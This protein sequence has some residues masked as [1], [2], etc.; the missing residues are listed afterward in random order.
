MVVDHRADLLRPSPLPFLALSGRAGTP[1][2]PHHAPHLRPHTPYPRRRM[3]S[4]AARGSERGFEA[5]WPRRER[6]RTDEAPDAP[7]ES[8]PGAAGWTGDHEHKPQ[9][10]QPSEATVGLS[11]SVRPN[12]EARRRERICP[13]GPPLPQGPSPPVRYL[14]VFR[15]PGV[16]IPGGTNWRVHREPEPRS[17]G[18][19]VGPLFRVTFLAFPSWAI[20]DAYHESAGRRPPTLGP[21][22]I[23]KATKP[24]IASHPGPHPAPDENEPPSGAC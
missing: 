18:N 6:R 7:C 4:R 17:I 22:T 21:R 3:P 13:A 1:T 12:P 5:L 11:G 10:T 19:A 9:P 20:E 8:W 23:Q 24:P 2:P 15:I 14:G 16:E